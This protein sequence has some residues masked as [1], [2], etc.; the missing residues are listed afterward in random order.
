[1]EIGSMGTVY[2][3]YLQNTINKSASV[4]DKLSNTD[5]ENASDEELMEACKGFES[6]FLEQVFDKMIE[7]TKVFSDE[8]ENNYAAKMVDCFKDT[9]IQSLTEKVTEQNSI[10]IAKTL[11][12][13]MKLQYGAV[14]PSDL[15]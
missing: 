12:E 1:M 8:K 9:A 10:G 14:K 3:D 4:S 13:Q 15:K 6:Y 7:S 11:Y 2:A 5:L